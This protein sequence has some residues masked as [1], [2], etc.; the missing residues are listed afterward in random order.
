MKIRIVRDV[1]L[2][3]IVLCLVATNSWAA[4]NDFADSFAYPA[5]PLND[6]GPPPHAPPGQTAWTTSSGNPSVTVP[7]LVFSGVSSSG[8]KVTL[9]GVAGN[10]GDIAAA[11]LSPTG[12]GSGVVWLGFLINESSGTSAPG[13]YAVVALSPGGPSFGLVFNQNLYGIDN[14]TGSSSDTAVTTTGPSSTTV[15]LVAKLDFTHATESIYVNPTSP[16]DPP[17]ARIRMLAAFQSA[18]FSGIALAQGFNV[19]SFNFDEVRVGPTFA[20]VQR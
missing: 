3:G 15:W 1:L 12:G 16:N 13:G 20:S 11:S 2:L 7:G 8:R 5:G 9:V 4:T 14:N 18:G 17:A 6:D 10:N 19:A